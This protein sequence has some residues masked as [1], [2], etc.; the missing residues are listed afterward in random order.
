EPLI[1]ASR[2]SP[3]IS[4]YAPSTSRLDISTS[5]VDDAENL[6]KQLEAKIEPLIQALKGFTRYNG[7]HR[8]SRRR[9]LERQ[10]SKVKRKLAKVWKELLILKQESQFKY[11]KRW[12][13]KREIRNLFSVALKLTFPEYKDE[14]SSIVC[15]VRDDGDY[16]CEDVLEIWPRLREEGKAHLEPRRVGWQIKRNVQVQQPEMVHREAAPFVFDIG[17]VTITLSGKWMAKS[18]HKLLRDGVDTWAPLLFIKNYLVNIYFPTCDI[19]DLS[20][21]D[22]L[23]RELIKKTLINILEYCKVDWCSMPCVMDLPCEEDD[24]FQ[25]IRTGEDVLI[26]PNAEG[27]DEPLIRAKRDSCDPMEDLKNLWYFHYRTIHINLLVWTRKVKSRLDSMSDSCTAT[28]AAQHA[29]W[30]SLDHVEPKLSYTG[31][32]SCSTSMEDLV[33]KVGDLASFLGKVEA[34]VSK[35]GYAIEEALN[36]AVKY[37]FLKNHRLA[38]CTF[39]FEEMLNEEGNTFVYLL[40]TQVRN[41]SF[42]KKHYKGIDQLKK[43]SELTLGEDEIWEEG[44]ERVLVLHLLKFTQVIA[45]SCNPVLPHKL[46]KHLYDLSVMFNSYCDS[47]EVGVAETKLLLCKATE[48][49]MEKCFQLLGITLES[50]S[51]GDKQESLGLPRSLLQVGRLN[52]EYPTPTQFILFGKI[53]ISD[54]YGVLYDG[55]GLPEA[56]DDHGTV[57]LFDCDWVGQRQPW[58]VRPWQS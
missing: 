27:Q 16:N 33:G 48:V 42:T 19:A 58:E 53:T 43:A 18:L 45:M 12:S 22:S 17:F 4:K 8:Y 35:A 14:E 15:S 20:D 3:E 7:K 47:W 36:C 38:V 26:Y 25:T 49:V 37:T 10:R 30:R 52:Q 29:K 5:D 28:G 1:Q 11:A 44:V 57:T 32:Q 21:M 6:S 54:A 50:S 13:L 56:T 31:F 41:R 9:A 23:R 51:L 55:W 2:N 46:C 34:R 40:N 24:K 39:S